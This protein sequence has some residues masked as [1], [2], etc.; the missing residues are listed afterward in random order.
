[1]KNPVLLG[2]VTGAAIIAGGGIAFAVAPR[3][4][5]SVKQEYC[6]RLDPILEHDCND[7]R[8]GEYTA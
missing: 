3:A 4:V 1:M 7:K 8:G 6:F 5:D 2:A